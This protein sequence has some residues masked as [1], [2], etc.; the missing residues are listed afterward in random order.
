MRVHHREPGCQDTA[1]V[2]P[3]PLQAAGV[4][5]SL[6]RVRDAGDHVVAEPFFASLKTELIDRQ[7]WPTRAAVRQAIFECIEV[8]FNRRRRHSTLGSLALAAYEAR[9]RAVEAAYHRLV[10]ET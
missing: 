10:R 9:A 7:V 2:F 5:P 6:G 3:R 8:W 4:L 1:R